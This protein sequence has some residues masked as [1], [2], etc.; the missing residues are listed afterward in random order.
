MKNLFKQFLPYKGIIFLVLVLMLAQ[1]FCEMKLPQY[2]QNMIDVGI[3]SKGLSHILPIELRSE[4]YEALLKDMNEPQ[5]R[6]IENL[7][8]LDEKS[9][10]EKYKLKDI[11]E[12]ELAKADEFLLEPVL[13]RYAKKTLQVSEK[14]N[15]ILLSTDNDA[16][17]KHHLEM[18]KGISYAILCS[19]EAGSDLHLIQKNY[20]WHT[21]SLMFLMSLLVLIIT[22]VIS[23]FSARIG[24]RI[25]KNLRDGLFKNVMTF[26]GAEMSTFS[27][28]SLITRATNDIQQV[29]QTCTMM[30]RMMLFAPCVCIWSIIRVYQTKAHMN[31][32]IVVGVIAITLMI[33]M[34]FSI[35]MPKFKVMQELVDALNVVSRELLTGLQVIRAFGREKTQ[36]TKFDKANKDLYANQLFVNRTMVSMIP[37]MMIIMYGLSIWITWVSAGKINMGELKVGT[38]TA[39]IAY[40]MEIVFSFMMITG[41]AIFIPRAGVAADRIVEVMDVETSVRDLENITSADTLNDFTIKFENV[42]FKYPGAAENTLENISFE[43]KQGETLAI[44]G[45]TGS[46]K[47]TLINLIPRFYDATGGL[48]TIGGVNVKKLSLTSLRNVIGYV[49]QKGLLFSGTIESN[50]RWGKTD[51]MDKEIAE[52]ARMACADKFI[53]EKNGDYNSEISQGGK[54]VSGGQRQRLAIARALIKDPKILIF[55]DSFSALDMKT[56]AMIRKEI[57]KKTE[58]K[59]KIIVAQRVGT[60]LYADKILVLDEGKIVGYGTH[61]ELMKTNSIYKDIAMSQLDIQDEA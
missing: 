25:G 23:F 36:E 50:I 5:R 48:I 47:T 21:G 57:S 58:D 35:A 37:L 20:M 41:M 2:T 28:S 32:V 61:N 53:A 15:N 14:K 38:M 55:D 54:N 45:A 12:S 24:A 22:T 52:V 6:Y 49:P 51:A 1:A 3:Q 43:I 27:T 34:L 11:S 16:D 18:E 19:E 39:F 8:F 30:L 9:D 26:S 60:I 10:N 13:T 29:Q 7:Y 44:I 59:V 4:E 31:Y 40:S 42:N 56:D 33:F 17:K 46:G